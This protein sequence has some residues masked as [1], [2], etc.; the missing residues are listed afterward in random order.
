MGRMPPPRA[1]MGSRTTGSSA[2]AASLVRAN[3]G[4]AQ[5]HA[6]A[7]H[8]RNQQDEEVEPKLL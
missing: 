8:G 3:R 6:C 7:D 1:M 5:A 4:D 2:M